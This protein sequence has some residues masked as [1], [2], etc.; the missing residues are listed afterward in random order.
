MI[1]IVDDDDAQR[2]MTAAMMTAAGRPWVE[3]SGGEAALDLL[4]GQAGERFRLSFLIS[5]CPISMEWRSF[6]ASDPAAA[7]CP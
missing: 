6:P 7:I 5:Q 3:A 2:R 1:L 4:N